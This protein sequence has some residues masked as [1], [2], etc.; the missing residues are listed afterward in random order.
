MNSGFAAALGAF[1]L[2]GLFP[3]Y[4]KL[5][6]QVPAMQIMAHRLFWCFLFVAGYLGLRQGWRWL[7]PILAQRRLLAM[8]CCSAVIIGGN[9]FLYIW[10]VV[11]DHIV[12]TSL[13]YFINPLV[14]VLLATLVFRERLNP[15]QWLAIGLAALGVAYLTWE[16]GRLPWIALCLALSF[17]SY[18]V[19]RK[20]AVVDSI[21]GLAVE[22][23]ILAPIAAA[24]LL[25]LALQG[26]GEF[27]HLGPGTDLLLIL[28][29]LVTAVPLILFAYGARRIPFATVGILQYLA[30]TLQLLSGVLVFG[31][32]F[33][34]A[35]ALGFACIWA[36]LAVYAADGLWRLRSAQART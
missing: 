22:S 8:L 7:P 24:Y 34:T 20:L 28:G 31:E 13:G 18:G 16:Y 4:W 10:A 2:W 3:M 19:I 14:N 15:R 1:A 35:Q 25:W 33:T 36:G 23:G 12:E 27:G 30:P 9:W 29:G 21:P 6:D 5:L 26:Q 17:A 11:S 32:P